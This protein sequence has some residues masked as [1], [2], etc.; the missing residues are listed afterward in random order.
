[1]VNTQSRSHALLVGASGER[2]G[3]LAL[4][5]NGAIRWGSGSSEHFDATL[6]RLRT[7]DT[8]VGGMHLTAG[9]VGKLSISVEGGTKGDVCMAT[10]A[11]V[12]EE[13][14]LVSCRVVKPGSVRVFI[15]NEETEAVDIDGGML[16]VVLAS[17]CASC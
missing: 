17:V 3:R 10:H 13:A 11:G 9:A 5:A 2:S 16:R 14:V 7:N 1:M 8:A 12:G 4:E 15:K 6:Q